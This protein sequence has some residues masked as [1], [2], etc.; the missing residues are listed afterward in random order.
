VAAVSDSPI[1]Y[2]MLLGCFGAGAVLG[3]LTMQ[4]ARARWSTE[5][6]AS[7]GVAILALMTVAAGFLHAMIGLGAAM[8]IGDAAWIVFIS[9]VSALL[10]RVAPD[11]V[12][13]GTRRVHA[14]VAGWPGCRQRALGRRGRAV[15][16][17]DRYVEAFLVSSWAGH[18]RQHERVTSA[19]RVVEDRLSTCMTGAPRTRHLVSANSRRYT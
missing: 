12:R 6:V 11:W 14:G 18:L 15:E 3:V 9:L 16:E 10:L 17:A 19:D 1:E 8:L 13:A 7:G 5:T 2:G 4:P